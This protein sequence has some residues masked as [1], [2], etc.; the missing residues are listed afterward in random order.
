MY[1]NAVNLGVLVLLYSIS[2]DLGYQAETVFNLGRYESGYVVI[3]IGWVSVMGVV[4]KLARTGVVIGNRYQ[5]GHHI[6]E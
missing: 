3:S 5:V 4:E 2:L 1:V 6:L